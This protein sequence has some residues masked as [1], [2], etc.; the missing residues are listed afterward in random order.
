MMPCTRY[1]PA[2]AMVLLMIAHSPAAAQVGR[3][4]VN[5]PV[6]THLVTTTFN[7][8]R[9]S[10]WADPAI[11]DSEI[12]SRNQTL[13]L[14]YNYITSL[15]GRTGGFGAS[16]PWTSLLSYDRASDQV[17]L[18]QSGQGD[19]ALTFDYNLFGAPAL[20]RAEFAR[21]RPGDYAGLHF[22]LTSPT[23]SYDS[24]REVNIGANRWS[25]KSTLNYSITRNGG[26]SWWDFYPSVRLFSDN[27]D[28]AGAATLSQN[29]L[30]GLE[31]HYSRTVLDPA[32]LSAGLIGSLGGKT[33]IDAEV[34]Q[35]PRRDLRLALGA[36]FATWPRGAAIVTYH[37]DLI[38]RGGAGE[39]NSFMLQLMHKF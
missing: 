6:D 19:V 1:L 8:V 17:L 16:L 33:R 25:L 30:W 20:P 10:T 5:T 22:S 38:D 21:H 11:G 39:I 24:D 13:S 28:V 37:R 3:Y 31:A 9:S 18:D 32:W 26:L 35:D 4:Y 27:R 29:P 7:G 15:G 12:R 23:G 36:G 14:S 2:L 34:L